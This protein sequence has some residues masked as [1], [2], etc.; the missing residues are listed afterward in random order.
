MGKS[1]QIDPSATCGRIICD[2]MISARELI[3]AK[4]YD[5]TEIVSQVLRQ[6]RE[7]LDADQLRIAYG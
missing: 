1:S 4:S 7:E 3:R 2:T 6:K 5:L